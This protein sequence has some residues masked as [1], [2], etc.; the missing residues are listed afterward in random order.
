MASEMVIKFWNLEK[1]K[2]SAD[3]PL[4]EIAQDREISLSGVGR[5]VR[6]HTGTS[7]AEELIDWRFL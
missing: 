4:T 5:L 1:G 7:K 3:R 2:F 6:E